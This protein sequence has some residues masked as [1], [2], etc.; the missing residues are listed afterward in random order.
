MGC[1]SDSP[2]NFVD[3]A[4]PC[5]NKGSHSIGLMYWLL[6]REI[7]RLRGNINR[8]GQWD[9][10]V[11]L[12]F[13]RDPED[14]KKADEEQRAKLEEAVVTVQPAYNTEAIVSPTEEY[15]DGGMEEVTDLEGIDPVNTTSFEAS[16]P[17]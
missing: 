9:V 12:F 10:P 16:V 14:L 8:D 7:L 13:H 1:D 11:D 6:A 5:N 15:V 2:L 4:V 17:M 3:V